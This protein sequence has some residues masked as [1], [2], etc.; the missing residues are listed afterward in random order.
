M[1]TRAMKTRAIVICCLVVAFGLALFLLART[2]PSATGRHA[3]YLP[4]DTVATVSLT[5]L[6]TITD[7]FAGSALGRFADRD[8]IHA[9]MA[10]MRVDPTMRAAYDQMYDN[11][12]TMLANPAF[13]T[14]F[15][16]DAALALLKPDADLLALDPVE[17]LRA[18]LVVFA[19]TPAPAALDLFARL[20]MSE[21]VTRENIDGLE[22]TR[23]LV[24]EDQVIYGYADGQTVLLAHAPDAIR[25]CLAARR[26]NEPLETLPAFREAVAFWGPVAPARTFV[27]AYINPASLNVLLARFEEHPWQQGAEMMQGGDYITFITRGTDKGLESKARYS[28]SYE[29]LGP[30][31]QRL[32][33]AASTNQTLHLLQEG[34]LAYTW[35]SMP[36]ATGLTSWFADATAEQSA[37][38]VAE[39]TL[40]A[41]LSDLERGLGP[42]RGSV[43]TALGGVR[44][45]PVPRVTFF[46]EVRDLEVAGAVVRSLRDRITSYGLAR[47]Q[48]E[49]VD[50][51]IIHSWPILPGEAAQPALVLTETMLYLANGVSAIKEILAATTP[52]DALPDAVVEQLGAELSER[53]IR[54]NSS[55]L[56]LYPERMSQQSH[57]LIQWINGIVAVTSNLSITRLSRELNEVLRATELIVM[58]TDL[59]HEQ[60][61]W[62]LTITTTP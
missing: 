57:D 60:A 44:I 9:I 47:E 42:Q 19:V 39:E 36:V 61:Q 13:R 41:A 35:A 43:L 23:I 28:Y 20:V 37:E 15:G 38:A 16:Q 14:V 48:Q 59:S 3:L 53:I 50:G 11:L 62:D 6:N 34:I 51:Q 58:T 46:L 55:S 10:E 56:V 45:F 31:M 49:V 33:D 27:R 1:K 22:L 7:T 18:S 2:P 17:A 4:Q 29:Q 8:N 54:A 32:V 52:A 30:T 24:D 26:S 12:T 25:T 21:T 5:Q 40:G